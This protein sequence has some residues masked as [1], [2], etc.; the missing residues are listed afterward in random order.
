M[1]G[2]GHPPTLPHI[3]RLAGGQP[4]LR[5]RGHLPRLQ[6]RSTTLTAWRIRKRNSRPARAHC[7]TAWCARGEVDDD[8]EVMV[9][10]MM[11]LMETVM[12]TV[13]VVID[14]LL[15][16]YVYLLLSR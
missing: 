7:A 3:S 5:R 1:A 16:S 4:L 2:K 6:R 11:M 8:Q 13:M 9:M 12:V 10:L 15:I 14:I